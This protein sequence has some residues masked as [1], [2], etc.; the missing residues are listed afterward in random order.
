MESFKKR[1]KA[2]EAKVAE[3]GIVLSDIQV[4][5]LKKK[6]HDDESCGE[7][8]TAHPCYLGSQD[9]FYVGNIKG[10][11]RIYQQTFV[12]T[13]SRIAIVKLYTEKTAITSADILNDRVI[14]FFTEHNIRLTRI[15]TDRGTEYCG[16]VENHAYQLYLGIEDIDHSKTKVRSPQ[17]NGICERFHRTI[18]DECYNIL[19]R[20][21]IYRSLEALQIDVDQW[22][23][24]LPQ[25][26]YNR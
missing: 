3:D 7:I 12:D 11:G 25:T 9:T 6:K 17:T 23:S 4:A 20:K 26:N 5:T 10:V 13:Y 22:L 18:K 2:L 14:P 21:K 24:K 1:L 16:N 15:L 19:F 8:E